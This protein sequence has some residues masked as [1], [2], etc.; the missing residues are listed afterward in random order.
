MA[1]TIASTW[2]L[3]LESEKLS[4]SISNTFCRN[5]REKGTRNFASCLMNSARTESTKSVLYFRS[6]VDSFSYLLK[7]VTKYCMIFCSTK[8]EELSKLAYPLLNNLMSNCRE[9]SKYC[10]S[11]SEMKLKILADMCCSFSGS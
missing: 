6:W 3:S 10:P 1:P 5:S 4:I 7:S 2:F 11:A 8:C 9:D